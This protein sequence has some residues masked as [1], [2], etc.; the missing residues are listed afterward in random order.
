MKKE[1]EELKMNKQILALFTILTFALTI[2]GIAYTHWQKTIN[3]QGTLNLAKTQIIIQDHNTTLTTLEIIE[4][5]P[6]NLMLNGTITPTQT[7]WTGIIIKNN[8]TTPATITSPTITT[9]NTEIWQTNFT[10]SE[11]HYGPYT[12]IPPEKW[13][14]ATTMPPPEETS[15]PRELQTNEM[16]VVWQNI[17]LSGSPPF[18]IEITVTYTATFSTWTDTITIKY[19]LTY[20]EGAP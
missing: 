7:L 5:T 1:K 10:H 11:H 3:I 16:L 18:T 14:E 19:T 13:N 12:T 2:T 6:H 4:S 15:L 17:T 8:G 9:N 20:Q